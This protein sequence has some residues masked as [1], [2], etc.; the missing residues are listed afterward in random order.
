MQFSFDLFD[1]HVEARIDGVC[2]NRKSHKNVLLNQ[3]K[4]MYEV[5]VV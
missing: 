2:K 3:L 1:L 5:V 4:L